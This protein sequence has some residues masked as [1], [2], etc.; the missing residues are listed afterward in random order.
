MD[1]PVEY[2]TIDLTDARLTSIEARLDGLE[3]RTRSQRGRWVER[4]MY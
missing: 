2:D 4:F 3:E 1:K